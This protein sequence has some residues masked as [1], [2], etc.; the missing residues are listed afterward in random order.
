MKQQRN[1]VNDSNEK[2]HNIIATIRSLCAGMPDRG[3]VIAGDW[4]K[5]YQ[6][7]TE[8]GRLC[9]S[10]HGAQEAMLDKEG[11]FCWRQHTCLIATAALVGS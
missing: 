3:M 6:T 4:R 8:S 11:F 2:K 5:N 1:G 9:P 10:T 7:S